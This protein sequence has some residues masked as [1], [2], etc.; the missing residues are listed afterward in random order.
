MQFRIHYDPN[1]TSQKM[2]PILMRYFLP[3]VGV[4]NKF[5]EFHELPG[6]TA[7]QITQYTSSLLYERKIEGKIIAFSADNTNSNFGGVAR[8]GKNNVFYIYIR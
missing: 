3:D 5:L 6:E 2:V 8:N 7:L 1:H 4:K